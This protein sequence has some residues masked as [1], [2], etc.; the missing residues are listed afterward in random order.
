[1]G[2]LD[3]LLR[4][5]LPGRR[6]PV[7]QAKGRERFRQR[8]EQKPR[9]EPLRRANRRR[10]SGR[11]GQPSTSESL[12]TS[13]LPYQF[14]RFSSSYG[15]YLDLSRD[16][17]ADRLDQFGLPVF[18]TPEQLADWLG[19][20][21]PTVA[22]LIQRFSNGDR[23]AS[24]REA[25]YH[26]HWL[27]KRSGGFRL[28]EAP[29]QVLKSVQSAILCDIL[30]RIPLHVYCHGFT[31]GRSIV[32]NAQPHVGSAV[33]V[34][35]DLENFYASVR[36][37]RVV[38]I[39][40]SVGYCREAAIWLGRLTTSALPVSVAFPKGDAMAV[41]PYLHRHLPQGAPSSPA[42]ANL[43]AYGLDVRL[44]GLGKSFGARYTRYGD[45][46]TFSGPTPFVR[47][48]RVFIPLVTQII[49]SERFRVNQ[50]KRKVLRNNQRQLVT[51]VVVN[52]HPN[53]SRK[54][55][56]RLKAILTN[57]IRQGP[58]SQNREQHGDFAAHL[59]GRVA[60]VCQLNGSRGAK[61]LE[62][63]QQIDWQR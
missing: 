47:S 42:L 26:Y 28:I 45:D 50:K 20:P 36:F 49:R 27:R 4:F 52:K 23:P 15:R 44:S 14:A 3:F 10:D 17:D 13:V 55:F 43:S 60:H 37:A 40:R 62:L 57:S 56:D 22:W 9:L 58:S 8:R 19:L 18:H 7:H 30:N 12:E 21:L 53:V 46:L 51:G 11:N 41:L 34:K 1:M 31:A 38:A 32:T 39:Y 16:G 33:L 63:Y 61:L 48:L 24:D 54:E 6:A 25:H 29:K 59:R 5:L 35:F 2:L